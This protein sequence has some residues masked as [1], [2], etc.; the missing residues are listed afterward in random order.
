MLSQ[1]S[2]YLLDP[3]TAPNPS[4]ETGPGSH[5]IA[6]PTSVA[7]RKPVPIASVR[8]STASVAPS[9]KAR[10]TVG[11]RSSNNAFRD[12]A[13]TCYPSPPNSASPRNGH[14]PNF[15]GSYTPSNRLSTDQA[16]TQIPTSTGGVAS[17]TASGRTNRTRRT[18]S[19]SK[20]HPGDQSHHPLDMLRASEKAAH[21]SP[22]L[23]KKHHVGTDSIDSL[24]NVAGG[25]YHHEGPYDAT[26]M[27][28]NISSEIA[29]IEAVS[30]SNDEAL[31]ATPRE[32]IQDSVERH[33]PLDGVAMVPPGTTD[34]Y[35][36]TYQYTEGTDMM[37]EAHAE[38]GPYKQWPGVVSH[39]YPI[40]SRATPADA[41]NRNISPKT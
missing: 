3:L 32:M 24:D 2:K 35:G 22:H 33:Y 15:D 37:R 17:S 30:R 27:A 19:L 28:R 6:A 26:L 1:A 23:R 7:Q 5:H 9:E 4:E 25:A 20:R 36:R 14:F 13:Q 34:R 29:P 31:K 38:G 41:V 16:S 18:S 39:T 11:V 12:G 8:S 10:S 40:T 21:R